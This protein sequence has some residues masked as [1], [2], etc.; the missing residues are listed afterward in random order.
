MPGSKSQLSPTSS[1]SCSVNVYVASIAQALG[2]G[3]RTVD[4]ANLVLDPESPHSGR[5][6]TEQPVTQVIDC[7]PDK[8]CESEIKGALKVCGR[9]EPRLEV[10]GEQRMSLFTFLISLPPSTSCPSSGALKKVTCFFSTSWKNSVCACVHTY[11]SY[12]PWFPAHPSVQT[13]FLKK[14]FVA[15]LDQNRLSCFT[16]SQTPC[17]SFQALVCDYVCLSHCQ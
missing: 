5:R 11:T 8:Y 4:K 3:D 6:H 1:G 2:P 15:T 16:L 14:A 13:A 9:A 17:F 10:A 7:S 12:P